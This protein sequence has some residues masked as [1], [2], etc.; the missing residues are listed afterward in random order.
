M[1]SSF[2]IHDSLNQAMD[3]R[4]RGNDGG[5]RDVH[6]PGVRAS[7]PLR[8]GRPRSQGCLSAVIPAEAGIHQGQRI[9]KLEI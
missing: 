4:L 9:S 2:G 3:S 5:R 6:V 8:A 1:N 7:G